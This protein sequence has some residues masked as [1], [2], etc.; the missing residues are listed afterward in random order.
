V[1]TTLRIGRSRVH[2]P[3]GAKD[4]SVF[5][6]NQ[7]DS[8]TCA[9]LYSVGTGIFSP[10]VKRLGREVNFSLPCSAKVKNEWSYTSAASICLHVVG[11]ENYYKVV[12]I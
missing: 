8:A 4:F 1:A 7:I 9:V 6:I 10:G 2:I 5:E 11:T 3:V 12:Q